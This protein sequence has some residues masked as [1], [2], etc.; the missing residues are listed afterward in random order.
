MEAEMGMGIE[1]SGD[2]VR[3]QLRECERMICD[4]VEI[5]VGAT[6]LQRKAGLFD[7]KALAQRRRDLRTELASDI[8]DA[9]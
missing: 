6:D 5:A 7:L 8:V 2:F 9:A 3:D 4:M 1:T